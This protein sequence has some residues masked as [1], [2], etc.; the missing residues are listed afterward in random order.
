W[1]EQQREYQET[2]AYMKTNKFRRTEDK[3]WQLVVQRL[4]ELSKANM[5]GTGYKLRQ[6]IGK[7]IKTR[8]KAIHSV[9]DNY[10]DLAAHMT[11]LAPHLEWGNIL[12]YAFISD[13]KLLKHAY[14]QQDITREPWTNPGNREIM[15]K[16]FKVKC[17]REEL[18]RLNVEIQRLCAFIVD[19]CGLMH[20][21]LHHL[22]GS[23]PYLAAELE[24]VCHRRHRIDTLHILRLDNIESLPGFTGTRT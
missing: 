10:N 13:F 19:E 23:D 2:L 3:L 16:Y 7:A 24:E 14:S 11:P 9:L 18:E 1:T 8:G 17:A 22:H 5:V 20:A 6:Q 15:A 12:D 4:F 21:Q